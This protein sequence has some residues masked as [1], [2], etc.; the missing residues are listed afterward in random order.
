VI[1]I[2]T[3]VLL[4]Y[5][6]QDDAVQSPLATHL[7]EGRCS[8]EAPGFLCLVAIVEIVWVCETSYGLP[9]SQVAAILQR[10]LLT[11]QLAVEDGETVWRALR[12]YETSKADFA[13][14][15]ILC[16]G[17]AQGCDIVVTFDKAAAEAGMT[18]LK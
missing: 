1:G 8:A 3:N 12:A 13:D 4:R 10:I 11:D 14:C 5:I 2:D 16:L 9:R 6:A 17:A 7:I 15:L 18:L